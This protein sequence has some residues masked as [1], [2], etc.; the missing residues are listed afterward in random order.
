MEI[1]LNSVF[2]NLT[3]YGISGINTLLALEKLGHNVM[4][5]SISDRC[6]YFED[7]PIQKAL[8]KGKFFNK[9][10]HC[11]RLF[12]QFALNHHVGNGLFVGWPIFETTEFS[13]EEKHQLSQVDLLFVCSNWAKGI[14]EQ[15]GIKTP[16]KIVELGVNTDV[17]KP[18]FR[19]KDD[20]FRF[21]FPGKFEVRKSFEIVT[22]IFERA[23][24]ITDN[25]EIIFLPNNFFIGEQ[26]REWANFLMSSTLSSKIKIL[27]RLNNHHQ[28]S[29]LYNKCDCVVS[30]SK[31]EGFNLPVLEGL[32]CGKQV[33]A[34]NYSA[35]T[36]Y[37]NSNNSI[38]VDVDGLE[39]AIDGVFFDGKKGDWALIDKKC[40][41]GLVEALRIA[42]KRGKIVNEEGIL[43]SQRLTWE[44]TAK[45]IISHLGEFN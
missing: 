24:S 42:Y 15:N 44:N 8:E 21:F 45:Q 36:Q 25:I 6:D 10:A 26:N 13:R 37:L 27:D 17:F 31:G 40:K 23:F 16:V 34:T 28:V 3:S 41:D 1:I 14:I 33:V 20:V 39:P 43:T 7:Q 32:A 22:E 2:S 11:I 35:H 4:A 18:K 12:H 19:V 30:F 38:L 29:D 5:V 9:N